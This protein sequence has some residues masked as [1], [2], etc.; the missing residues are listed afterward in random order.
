MTR[1]GR[2][3]PRARDRRVHRGDLGRLGSGALVG[4]RGQD[5]GDRHRRGLLPG[6]GPRRLRR[7]RRHA[8]RRTRAREG[9]RSLRGRSLRRGSGQERGALRRHGRLGQGPARLR[10]KDGRDVGDASRDRRSRPLAFGPDGMRLRRRLAR[11]QGLSAAEREG[12]PLLRHEGAVRLGPRVRG[13]GSLRRRPGFPARSTGSARAG[14]GQPVHTTS[15]AH[16]RTLYVDASGRVWA[17]TSGSGLVL[18]I[19]RAGRVATLYDSSKPEITAIAGDAS[20]R[21]WAAAGAA[22]V[23]SSG[24]EPISVPV[25]SSAPS[26]S[27]RAGSRY[28]RRQGSLEARGHRLRLDAAARAVARRLARRL[29]RGGPPLRGGRAGPGRLERSRGGRLRPR[30]RRERRRRRGGDGAQGK[31]LRA[32]PDGASLLRTFDEKQVTFV[33]GDDVGLNAATAL[34]RRRSGGSSGE[35]VSPVKDTGRTSRFGA[36]RWEGEAPGGSRV[37]FSFRSGDAATPDTTWS[38]WSNWEANARSLPIAAPDARFLQ[39]KLRVETDGNALPA[40]RRTEAAYRNRNAAPV[41]ESVVA[42]E[43]A[44]VLA[45]SGSGGS[46]VYESSAP[47]EK[48][49]FTSLD[50]TK[51]ESSPRK[52]LPQGLP[53]G[54]VE[55]DGSG[56]RHARRT[57]LEFRPSA[58]RSGSFPA[59]RPRELLLLRLDVAAR[60]RVRLSRHGVGRRA[61]PGRGQDDGAGI[62][63]GPYRQHAARDPRRVPAA[64]RPQDRGV[65]R[66]VAPHGG[67]VQPRREKVDPGRSRRT[68]SRILRRRLS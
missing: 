47:D 17:G 63:A 31:A 20:G 29:F 33:A 13:P 26:K 37:E 8:R 30:A 65:G 51:S 56:L 14:Q 38:A 27:A 58:G 43:P 45:R 3:G 62:R 54:A 5:L 23:S 53:D 48:G 52:L 2:P 44:E 39:W 57:T 7:R 19:D 4:R 21:V 18:R 11:R 35:Y 67:R 22:D 41:I 64:G 34:Y 12:E 6:R 36:F 60:R 50:E 40:I 49:I 55:G 66:R 9:R 46:N 68:D 42:L 10:R 59:G 24:S 16:V 1:A 28:R 32:L 61:E 15:D 25:A